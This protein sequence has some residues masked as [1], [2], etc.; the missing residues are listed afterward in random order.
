MKRRELVDHLRCHGCVLIRE[1]GRHSIYGNPLNGANAPVPRHVEIDNRLAKM[2]CSQL[3][4]PS[5]R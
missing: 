4:I 1:G 5:I 2:I 3:G